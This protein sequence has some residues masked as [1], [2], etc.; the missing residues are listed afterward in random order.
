MEIQ[1]GILQRVSRFFQQNEINK[2]NIHQTLQF[3]SN[4]ECEDGRN[5][6]EAKSSLFLNLVIIEF[7]S[8]FKFRSDEDPT[9]L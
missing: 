3:T 2:I 4:K 6:V 5:L 7:S 9:I 1:S 8:H